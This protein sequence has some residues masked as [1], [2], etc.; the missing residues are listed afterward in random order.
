MFQ[1]KLP[2]LEASEGSYSD[3]IRKAQE[4]YSLLRAPP[5]MVVET[6]TRSL[7]VGDRRVR[8]SPLEMAVI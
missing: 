4:D 8:L 7:A 3:L 5:R 6:A 2:A 1:S